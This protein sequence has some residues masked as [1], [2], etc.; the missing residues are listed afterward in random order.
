MVASVGRGATVRGGGDTTRLTF[1]N[2]D[3]NLLHG[4]IE[5]G[6]VP[7][8]QWAIFAHC[9]ACGKKS[10]TAVR[11]SRAL[12][13]H[14]IGVLRFD[15]TGLDESEGEFGRGLS[16]DIADLEDA[17]EHMRVSGRPVALVVGHS[18][19]G[20]AA[21]AVASSHP[22]IRAVATIGAPFR[23]RDTQPSAIARGGPPD[24]AS[25]ALWDGV[26]PADQRRAIASPGKALLVIHAADDT[27][28]P[29]DDASAL[30]EAAP[31]P[32]SQL[33]LDRG[34]HFIQDLADAEYVAAGIA[35]WAS[36][37]VPREGEPLARLP[38]GIVRA[39]ETGI[40]KFQ[41]AVST[42]SGTLIADEP[43]SAGGLGSGPAPYELLAAAL[44]ACTVM[45]CRLY[46]DRK[47]WN[48][49]RV[50]AEVEREARGRDGTEIYRKRVVFEGDLDSA[51]RERLIEIAGRCPVHRTLTGG[52]IV[53]ETSG[54]DPV[55]DG[56]GGT[57]MRSQ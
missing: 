17:V 22:E 20:V 38:D 37:H 33:L 1:R 35:A 21:L 49:R 23:P 27:V 25:P 41:L 19:G 34:E 45:T 36:R 57:R 56:D 24:H 15:F 47:G 29:V 39:E 4:R 13:R 48:L 5:V 28:V 14:G 52:G 53:I 50:S 3:G 46:A 30:F 55:V 51:Q 12:A 44:A 32:K 8:R 43:S 9:L 26:E 6:P 18:M 40:G 2:R 31:H 7:V 11:I 10:N 16:Q 42:P 54:A